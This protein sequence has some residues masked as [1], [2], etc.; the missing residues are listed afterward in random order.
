MSLF[1]ELHYWSEDIEKVTTQRKS[2]R[3]ITAYKRKCSLSLCIG[4]IVMCVVITCIGV[5]F[6]SKYKEINTKNKWYQER[7]DT[8]WEGILSWEAKIKQ[9]SHNINE[10]KQQIQLLKQEEEKLTSEIQSLTNTESALRSSI[11]QLEAV[12]SHRQRA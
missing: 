5:R 4:I 3:T 9:T 1:G 12:I 10:L 7:I 11:A 8:Y 2:K 6:V